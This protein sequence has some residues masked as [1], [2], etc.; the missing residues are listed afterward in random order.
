M[1][2]TPNLRATDVAA[3]LTCT[4]RTVYRYAASGELPA[5]RI[6]GKRGV[7]FRQEDVDALLVPRLVN[8]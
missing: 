6:P 5:Y 2:P 8:G 1:H 3:Q 4:P 7:W